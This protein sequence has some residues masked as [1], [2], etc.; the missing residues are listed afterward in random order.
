MRTCL[1]R[2]V[3]RVDS[4]VRVQCSIGDDIIDHGRTL[5][6]FCQS[7]DRL[8]AARW[9]CCDVC[10]LCPLSLLTLLRIDSCMPIASDTPRGMR[11]A[12]ME[13]PVKASV[14]TV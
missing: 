3:T 8:L 5:H 14:V 12:L 7:K 2:L 13:L 11:S 1:R 4:L 10:C 9:P 6:M